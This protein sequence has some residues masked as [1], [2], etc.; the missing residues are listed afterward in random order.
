L[1]SGY[2]GMTKHE[3][4][5]TSSSN[6]CD[7]SLNSLDQQLNISLM[8]LNAVAQKNNLPCVS[9]STESC[10]N[11]VPA[12]CSGPV[13]CSSSHQSPPVYSPIGFPRN[14]S[15][16]SSNHSQQVMVTF[17]F[18]LYFKQFISCVYCLKI[19]HMEKYECINSV[20]N[21]SDCCS[22]GYLCTLHS[23]N[24]LLDFFWI[25]N[26][27]YTERKHYVLCIISGFCCDVDEICALLGY[28]TAL[29]GNSVL[30]FWD[31]LSVYLQGSRGLLDP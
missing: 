31:N 6:V 30:T 20:D 16:R 15:S 10:S 13:S 27:I 29:S 22:E 17:L 2:G 18:H 28:Y 23:T 26:C 19:L 4:P 21:N 8:K 5:H 24:L 9:S 1:A 7:G 3:V 25:R 14:L 11:I 12:S